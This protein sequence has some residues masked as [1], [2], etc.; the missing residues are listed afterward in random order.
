MKHGHIRQETDA[1]NAAEAAEIDNTVSNS[2]GEHP[3]E[4]R[5]VSFFIPLLCR[6]LGRGRGRWSGF[7]ITH[8]LLVAAW[9]K[10]PPNNFKRT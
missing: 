10:K 2:W 5:R 3:L 8:E 4:P 6:C 9:S 7:F 1:R